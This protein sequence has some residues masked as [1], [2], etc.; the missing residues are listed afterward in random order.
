MLINEGRTT[1]DIQF[2]G[3]SGLWQ[4]S[5]VVLNQSTSITTAMD[6]L[7]KLYPN[8]KVR[9]VDSETKRIVDMAL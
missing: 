5:Y 1:V 2:Q 6:R 9:A 3:P 7:K 4:T 8:F